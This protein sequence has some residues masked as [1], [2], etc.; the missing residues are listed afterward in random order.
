[1]ELQELKKQAEDI[2]SQN[3]TTKC[4][5]WPKEFKN[6][7]VGLMNKGHSAHSLSRLTDISVSTIYSWKA[8]K[9]LK[10]KKQFKQ[11]KVVD[12]E[13]KELSLFWESG[14]SIKGL[15]FSQLKELLKEGLL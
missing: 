7:A 3:P 9:S 6:Q 2:R 15:N 13:T 1:M 14:L 10:K 8:S 5:F 12:K 4:I 11:I